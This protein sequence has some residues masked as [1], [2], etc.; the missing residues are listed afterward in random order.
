MAGDWYTT[1]QG[2][3]ARRIER[4]SQPHGAL[5]GEVERE[6]R[7][8]A[9]E[10]A[11]GAEKN[12]WQADA[13]IDRLIL[14]VLLATVMLAL[15]AGF[16]RAAGRRFT[17]PFTPSA[18]A[19]IGAALGILLVMYRLLQQPGLD[20]ATTV[21]AA[22]FLGLVA[23]AVIAGAG[24]RAMRAEESGTQFRELAVPPEEPP[25]RPEESPAR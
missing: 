7:A 25:A 18:L 6:V 13:G 9:R 14:L 15:A 17:P 23:L 21:K 11:Q 4:L 20:E 22:P 24:S 16:L 5:A 19:A 12:A 1:K 3:E 10:A 2:E 8:R